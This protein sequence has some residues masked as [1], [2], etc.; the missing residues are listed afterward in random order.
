MYWAG[1]VLGIEH[2]VHFA[3]WEAVGKEGEDWVRVGETEPDVG[4]AEE[5]SVVASGQEEGANLEASHM[6]DVHKL[7]E[8]GLKDGERKSH[9]LA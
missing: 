9:H 7:L 1:L 5:A 4:D 6:E 8:E 3:D 2:V